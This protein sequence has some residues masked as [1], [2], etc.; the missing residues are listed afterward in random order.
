[1]FVVRL[2]R[3]ELLHTFTRCG[4]PT[5][6]QKIKTPAMIV[7]LLL[8][9]LATATAQSLERELNGT[10]LY[11]LRLVAQ[12]AGLMHTHAVTAADFAREEALG[13]LHAPRCPY[14]G[15]MFGCDAEGHLT[16]I[17]LAFADGIVPPA[18]DFLA[19][20]LRPV[21]MSSLFH[22][23]ASNPLRTIWSKLPYGPDKLLEHPA[24]LTVT[25]DGCVAPPVALPS[26]LLLTQQ[27]RLQGKLTNQADFS[28]ICQRPTGEEV[29]SGA[30]FVLRSVRLGGTCRVK[31][32]NYAL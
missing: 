18:S 9:A 16:F 5:N 8:L 25:I 4:L 17:T 23:D 19:P 14:S 22:L 30:V 26:F 10:T 3:L 11:L 13:L 29:L 20:L 6:L 7:F 32:V 2:V 31:Y 15:P 1:M 24:N 27:F 28:A 12:R 21:S